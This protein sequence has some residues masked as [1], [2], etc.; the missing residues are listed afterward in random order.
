VAALIAIPTAGAIQVVTREIWQA[1]A[2]SEQPGTPG[3][4]A[5]AVPARP[6][7]GGD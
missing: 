5:P 4:S 3:A 7:P 1:T 2:P 6:Q